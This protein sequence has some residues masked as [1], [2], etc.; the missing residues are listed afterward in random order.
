MTEHFTNVVYKGYPFTVY[1]Y[2]VPNEGWVYEVDSTPLTPGMA[3]VPGMKKA[4]DEMIRAISP[5]PE[6]RA[7]G[8][9]AFPSLR[10]AKDSIGSAFK[11]VQGKR[12][13][14]IEWDGRWHRD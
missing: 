12:W 7:F 9:V 13:G 8:F 4:A 5:I 2:Q 3:F 6:A 14:L 10:I 1:L 11:R